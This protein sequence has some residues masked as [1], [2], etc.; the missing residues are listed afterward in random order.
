ML[1]TLRAP[2]LALLVCG[3][4]AAAL[5][6]AADA[7]R[8]PETGPS[9]GQP[10]P[11]VT[12]RTLD[13]ATFRLGELRGKV[14]VLDF[15]ATWCPPCVAMIPH[16]RHLA[17]RF[18]E[19]PFALVGVSADDDPELLREF[20][21]DKRMTWTHLPDGPG[22]PVQRLYDVRHFPTIYVIDAQ[23]VIRYKD[24]RDEALERAVEKLVAE[25]GG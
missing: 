14:V 25:A 2:L 3:L 23:G 12:A 4:V 19:S 8:P 20:V 10:A 13:G 7:G 21:R 18:S 11:D 1:R 17:Q 15:W 16:E 24:V 5:Y 9:V 6:F 22:G